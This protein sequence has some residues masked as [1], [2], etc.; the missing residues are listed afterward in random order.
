MSIVVPE[1]LQKEDFRFVLLADKSKIPIESEW[2]TTNN[3]KYNDP[4]LLEHLKNGGNYGVLAGANKLMIVDID[5]VDLIPE[6]D[7]LFPD[8]LTVKT[9]GGKRHYYLRLEG[10]IEQNFIVMKNGAGELRVKNCQVVAPG[11][12]H[13]SGTEYEISNNKQVQIMTKKEILKRLESHLETRATS[14][15][16]QMVVDKAFLDTEVMPKLSEYIRNLINKD[17]KSYTPDVYGFPSRSERDQKIVVTLLLKGFGQYV[18]SI[19]DLYPIGDKYKEH[20]NGEAYL[21]RCIETGRKY[22]GV[23]NDTSI[24]LE[25]E[26]N[27]MNDRVLRNKID[28][29]LQQISKL[30]KWSDI[31]YLIGA[32]AYKT[33]ISKKDLEKRLDI[34][35][36]EKKETII[37]TMNDIINMKIP[38]IQFFIENLIPEKSLIFVQ[39][40]PGQFKSLLVLYTCIAML[41]KKDFLNKLKTLKTP[42]ILYYDLEN[43]I[44]DIKK[45]ITSLTNGLKVPCSDIKNLDICKTFKLRNVEKELERCKDYEVIVLDSYRRFLE[46]DE[47]QSAN[48]NKFYNEFLKPL[49][50]MGKTVIVILHEKKG[51]YDNAY[52]GARLEMVR[53]S[54]DI[55]AQP[56][57]VY[58]LTKIGENKK[59]GSKNTVTDLHLSLEKNRKSVEFENMIFR[60]EFDQAT[61]ST[62]LTFVNFGKPPKPH[63]RLKTQIADFIQAKQVAKRKE[64]NEHIMSITNYTESSITKALAE[65]IRN[66]DIVQEQHGEY[67]LTEDPSNVKD[68]D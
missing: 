35:N 14:I 67:K 38:E 10:D 65:L 30:D 17:P 60:V 13:P 58:A 46:G 18:K 47:N 51:E 11:S 36:D 49:Q 19:F 29:Y 39:G 25:E 42:K 66:K 45:R 8:T 50:E 68:Q 61:T 12:I 7:E 3:Y 26:I 5:N 1:Q 64:I 21:K 33:K 27:A 31:K 52:E 23:T 53:G 41:A 32:I 44:L 37:F 2:T 54:G 59:L 16:Q 48:T 62:F 43:E 57:L 22:S 34:I 40:K 63:E 55:G 4:K 15:Q 20:T 28:F 24:S 9:G 56:D 6:M